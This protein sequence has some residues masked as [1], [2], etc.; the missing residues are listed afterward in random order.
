MGVGLVIVL[1]IVALAPYADTW[2]TPV[3]VHDDRP[4][5]T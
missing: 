4:S 5:Q 2:L 3:L 1:L